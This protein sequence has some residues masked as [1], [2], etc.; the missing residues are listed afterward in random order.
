MIFR[1][2]M[3]KKGIVFF[4][5]VLLLGLSCHTHLDLLEREDGHCLLCTLA[6]GFLFTGFYQ[7]FVF[8]FALTAISIYFPHCYE[9]SISHQTQF[10]APPQILD[11]CK[12]S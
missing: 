8:F 11:H 12:N 1:N 5:I 4:F 9:P 6:D 7:L 10:R 3:H 2:L